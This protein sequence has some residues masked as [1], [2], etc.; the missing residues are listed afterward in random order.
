MVKVKEVAEREELTPEQDAMITQLLDKIS[1]PLPKFLQ[2]LDEGD[3]R[4]MVSKFLVARRWKP[5]DAEDMLRKTIAFREEQ[6]F[7]DLCWFPSAYPIRGYDQQ[8]INRALN[9]E[10]RVAGD[11]YDHAV[12]AILPTFGMNYHY[13]DKTGHPVYIERSGVIHLRECIGRMRKMCKVGEDPA[14]IGIRFHCGLN[15]TGGRLARYM[16]KKIREETHGERRVLGITAVLD[17]SGLGYAHMWNPAIDIF[18]KILT[19]DQSYYPEGLHRLFVVNCPSMI[20]FAYSLVKGHLDPRLQAKI[21]FVNPKET[22]ETLLQVIDADKL[23]AF[24]GGKCECEGGCVPMP[25]DGEDT[26]AE[27]IGDSF[28]EDV[29]VHA[30]EDLVKEFALLP[31]EQIT[32]EFLSTTGH[33]VRFDAKFV[34]AHGNTTVVVAPHKLKDSSESFEAANHGKL[35]LTWDNTHSWLKAKKLQIRIIRSHSQR[36]CS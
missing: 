8:D 36:N 33:D 28:T 12:K 6:K 2:V 32:W 7:D 25:K 11:W 14:A 27:D 30:G 9:A 3:R 1:N 17:A 19:V 15:E 18:K 4:I 5:A 24:L 34:D 13:Y 16:D 35:V 21:V 20:M 23:P 22:T 29:K 10:P 26:F 31:R